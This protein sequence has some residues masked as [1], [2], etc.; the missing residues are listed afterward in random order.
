MLGRLNARFT[1]I[2]R[3]SVSLRAFNSIFDRVG[4]FATEN[5]VLSLLS[6]KCLSVLLYATEV[7]PLLS[8]DFV[9]IS[10]VM[11]RVIMKIFF[12]RSY[13][14]AVELCLMCSL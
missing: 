14:V 9:S 7:C 13:A 5:L 8:C 3:N 6:C 12:S 2:G 4:R 11:T 1:W 10:F